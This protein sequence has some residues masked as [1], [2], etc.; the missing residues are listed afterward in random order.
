[1]RH[2]AMIALAALVGCAATPEIPQASAREHAVYRAVALAE[3]SRDVGSTTVGF[4]D[5]IPEPG[6]CAES[7]SRSFEALCGLPDGIQAAFRAANAGEARIRC[8]L[9]AIPDVRCVASHRE[10]RRAMSHW[11]SRVG[12]SA[13]G[14]HALVFTTHWHRPGGFSNWVHLQQTDDDWTVVGSQFAALYHTYR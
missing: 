7:D 1:M 2:G 13:D 3:G 5:E 10:G 4:L 11:F 14:R 8:A 9:L 6:D 12:F